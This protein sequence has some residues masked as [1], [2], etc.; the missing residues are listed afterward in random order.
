MVRTESVHY[1]IFMLVL[2]VLAL[3][4][5]GLEAATEPGPET[6]ALLH[7]AD[8]AVC[9]V[10]FLDFAYSLWRAESRWRYFVTWGW[11][12]L[13][14]SIPALDAARWGRVARITR[15]FR[16][17]RAMRV[18]TLLGRALLEQ[19]A[20][21]GVLAAALVTIL[22][23]I[24][25]SIAILQVET[26]AGANITGAEDALWWAITTMTTVG[27]GDRYPV[28]PEGRFVAVIL[29]VGGVGLFGMFSGL[30]AAWFVAPQTT[31]ERDDV[32]AL[33]DE[34]AALREVLEGM[35]ARLPD[36]RP[37]PMVRD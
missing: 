20:R 22:L 34:V 6:R 32:A 3:V 2:S 17:L 25:S 23:L 7:Q 19:R 30:L 14:S 18:S 35:A 28:T 31:A 5:L 16:V 13:L 37:A 12:D 11:M 1:Q 27:Y 15:L 29:M 24:G 33:R 26:G 4:A 36:D 21:S 9:G 8:I 10:F